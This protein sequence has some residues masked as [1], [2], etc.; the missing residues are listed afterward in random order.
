MAPRSFQ[1]ALRLAGSARPD[2]IDDLSLVW[3]AAQ[4]ALGENR[5]SVDDDLEYTAAGSNELA[6]S[7]EC[8]LQVRRQTG[9]AGLVVS[10]GAVFDLD[11]HQRITSPLHPTKD[12]GVY[13]PC[14]A[15]FL[16]L[17]RCVVASPPSQECAMPLYVR[18]LLVTG[19][20][21]EVAVAARDHREHLRDLDARGK[22][23]VA[24]EFKNGEGFLD[25]FEAEDLLEAQSIGGASPSGR[26]LA[27]QILLDELGSKS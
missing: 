1:R 24:G 6:R 9:G 18:T 15:P 11:S 22:L 19:P 20:P 14:G 16:G 13:Q 12:A 17:P 21:D 2:E 10:L 4:G 23:R 3:K 26:L 5:L 27:S 8:R 25:V 7:T